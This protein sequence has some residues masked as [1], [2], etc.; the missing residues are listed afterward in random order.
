MRR[1][2]IVKYLQSFW[3]WIDLGI[4]VLSIIAAAFY[5]LRFLAVEDI[6]SDVLETGGN[7]YVKIQV[8][9]K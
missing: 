5:I 6:G 2:G 8:G 9:E 3:T 4:I 1:L 7:I